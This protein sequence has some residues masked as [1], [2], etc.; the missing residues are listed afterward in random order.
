[1][2]EELLNYKNF[3]LTLLTIPNIILFLDNAPENVI[4]HLISN[5]NIH[6][7]IIIDNNYQNF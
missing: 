6:E 5:C 7:E 4:I 1:M 2:Y 3:I